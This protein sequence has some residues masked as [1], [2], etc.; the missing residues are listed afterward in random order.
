MTVYERG[1]QR[2]SHVQ[3]L[4]YLREAVDATTA[5]PELAR[6]V[7]GYLGDQAHPPF[8]PP[9]TPLPS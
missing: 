8:R 1:G 5:T 6:Y 2:L 9:A 3:A 4:A 7:R